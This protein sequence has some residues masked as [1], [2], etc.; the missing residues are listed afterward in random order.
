MFVVLRGSKRKQINILKLILKASFG[1]LYMQPNGIRAVLVNS[2]S[3][4]L[5]GAA[6]SCLLISQRKHIQKIL[7]PELRGKT[8]NRRVRS[9]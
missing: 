1:D 6:A 9:F 3:F 8:T 2:A 5:V 4:V 7:E